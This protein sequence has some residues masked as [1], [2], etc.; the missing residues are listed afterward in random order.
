MNP[1]QLVISPTFPLFCIIH[2]TANRFAVAKTEIAMRTKIAVLRG[3]KEQVALYPN[4]QALLAFRL[5]I[6]VLIA[7]ILK[8]TIIKTKTIVCAFNVLFHHLFHFLIVA[9]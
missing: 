7:A 9:S 2:I 1:V 6:T 3:V 5:G 8:A 4:R